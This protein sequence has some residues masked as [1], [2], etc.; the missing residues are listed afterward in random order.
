M[1][2]QGGGASP[3][4]ACGVNTPQAKCL[5][6]FVI[7]FD[8]WQ[9]GSVH[10]TKVSRDGNPNPLSKSDRKRLEKLKKLSLN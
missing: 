2:I 3:L 9:A 5:G 7:V 6:L 8:G 1:N 4:V 10:E